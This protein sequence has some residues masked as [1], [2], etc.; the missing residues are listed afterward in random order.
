MSR[1]QYYFTLLLLIITPFQLRAD[2]VRV[3]SVDVGINGCYKVGCWTPVRVVLSDSLPETFSVAVETVDSDGVPVRFQ[4]AVGK[5]SLYVKH[6]RAGASMTVFVLDENLNPVE[7]RVFSQSSNAAKNG[8]RFL[9]PI[10]TERPIFLVF[11]TRNIAMSDAIAVRHLQENRRPVLITVNDAANELPDSPNG[12]ECVSMVVLTMQPEIFDNVQPDSPQIDAV[13]KWLSRGGN[14][15]FVGGSNAEPLV[16]TSGVLEKFLPGRFDRMT[17]LRQG[18]VVEL[19]ARSQR[20]LVM[21]GSDETPFLRVPHFTEPRGT[22]I[23]SDGDLVIAS[24]SAVGFGRLTYFAGDLSS[25]PLSNWKDR[26]LLIT[27]ALGWSGD[28][29]RQFTQRNAALIHLGYNDVSG[30]LRSALD[31]FGGITIVPFSLI[32]ILMA[33]YALAVGGL[34]WLLVHRLLKKPQLTWLTLPLWITL[35]CVAAYLLSGTNSVKQPVVNQV[36]MIDIDLSNGNVR[37]SSWYAMYSADTARYNLTAQ[38]QSDYG[39][40]KLRLCWNGLSGSGLGGMTPKTFSPPVWN[41]GYTLQVEQP[42]QRNSENKLVQVPLATRSTKSFFAESYTNGEKKPLENPTDEKNVLREEQGLPVGKLTLPV[43][44]KNAKIVAGRWA[45]DIGDVTANVP[46]TID[47]K[48]TRRL[49]REIPIMNRSLLDSTQPLSVTYNPQSR[50]TRYILEVMTLYTEIGGYDALGVQMMYQELLELGRLLP[51]DRAIVMGNA[52]EPELL[53]STL[54]DETQE[55]TNGRSDVFVRVVVPIER[56][57]KHEVT[58]QK[59]GVL[60]SNDKTIR[61]HRDISP[62]E[63]RKQLN[64]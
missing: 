31:T 21:T 8:T 60:D 63:L 28:T 45:V 55:L 6:G 23:A 33:V 1:L 2:T 37:Q 54:K 46:K 11:G 61:E 25:A 12:M 41:E 27:T 47:A 38:T 14:V 57:Q 48:M 49:V 4:S 40:E 35:F 30:Q 43:S 7:S 15:F 42:P 51:T 44:L 32:L 18:E 29:D 5:T 9:A 17:D 3:Q 16:K 62:D 20:T 13:H 34:D 52:A 39:S 22:V 64:Q 24:R 19:F 10:P 50:D 53:R 59:R 26:H 58:E 36:D 56:E